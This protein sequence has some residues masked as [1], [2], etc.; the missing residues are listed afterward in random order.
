MNI[1]LLLGPICSGKTTWAIERVKRHN[2]L[3]LSVDD[4]KI[5]MYCALPGDKETEDIISGIIEN[6]IN[7]LSGN[8]VSK[9]VI[10]DGFKL[11]ID[12][13][14]YLVKT[15]CVEIV[16]FKVDLYTANLRNKIREKEDGI[17]IEPEE[18]KRYNNEF[19]E[20]ISSDRFKKIQKNTIV[21]YFLPT[22]TV[23]SLVM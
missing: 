22:K 7:M 1:I 11:D 17:F 9:D 6:S 10:I 18:I 23:K 20:F 21:T 13:I 5:M 19:E 8:D 16:I 3:R 2:S 4:L 12:Q 15:Y 14:E